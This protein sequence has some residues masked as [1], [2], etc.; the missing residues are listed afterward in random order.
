[1]TE[2][3]IPLMRRVSESGERRRA[4]IRRRWLTC[5]A[6][7]EADD[8]AAA[9]PEGHAQSDLPLALGHA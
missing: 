2:N 4:P 1:M 3:R 8:L 7:H 6:N 9:G 5:R